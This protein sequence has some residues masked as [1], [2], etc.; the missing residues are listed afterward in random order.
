MWSSASW[1]CLVQ[2]GYRM[3]WRWVCKMVTFLSL[4][5]L[6]VASIP[7]VK[8]PCVFDSITAKILSRIKGMFVQSG[9]HRSFAAFCQLAME[10]CFPKFSMFTKDKQI[11][12]E[13]FQSNVGLFRRL[14]QNK[15]NNES[16]FIHLTFVNIGKLWQ[17]SC[18][19]RWCTIS[20]RK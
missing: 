11:C 20:D 19:Q 17:T 6:K 1:T 12:V 13:S 4:T 18:V 16:K 8:C 14:P 7:T 3:K 15:I 2:P 10:H 5:M 9:F